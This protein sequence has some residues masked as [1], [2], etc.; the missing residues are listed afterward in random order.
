M[1]FNAAEEYISIQNLSFN[2]PL[3]Q[4]FLWSL[5]FFG[6]CFFYFLHFFMQEWQPWLKVTNDDFLGTG[7][8]KATFFFTIGTATFLQPEGLQNIFW[9][10]CPKVNCESQISSHCKKLERKISKTLGEDTFCVFYFRIFNVIFFLWNKIWHLFLSRM[11]DHS[12]LLW[13]FM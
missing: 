1:S 2:N 7:P 11:C 9:K 13:A 4:Y 8:L 10:N 6:S 12:T 3:L 5:I